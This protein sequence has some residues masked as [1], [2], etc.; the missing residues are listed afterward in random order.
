MSKSKSFAFIQ[1][2]VHA[3]VLCA[4]ACAAAPRALA[5]F[6]AASVLGFVH[7]A[8]GAAVPQSEVTLTNTETHVVRHVTTDEAGRYQFV[9]VPVGEYTVESVAPGFEKAA[10]PSFAL[11]VNAQQRVDLSMPV[12]A[13][14]EQVD[15]TAEPTLLETETSSRG[16]VIGEY[17][18]QNLPLNG[19]SYADLALLVPGVRKSVLENQ[20]T[21]SREASFNV[22]GQRSA[23]NNFLLDGLDNNNYGTSNQGFANEN[24]PPSP[25]AI[26]EFRVETDNYSAEYGRSSGA[27]I[28]ATTRSG[29]DHIAGEIWEY[30]R[31]TALNAIG[32]FNVAGGKPTLIRNQFGG[33][34]GGPILKDRYFYFADYEGTRQIAKAFQTAVLPTDAQKA[35]NLGYALHNPLTAKTYAN[36]VVPTA[37]FSPLARLVFGALPAAPATT[38]AT[39]YTYASFPRG[40]IQD[41][42]GDG[43]VDMQLTSRALLFTR[44]SQHNLIIFDPPAIPGAAGGNANGNVAGNNKQ[45]AVGLTYTVSPRVIADVR[46]GSTWNRGGKS[47]IGVGQQSLLTQAG[48]TDGLPT[49]PQIV[50]PLNGQ[51]ITGYTQFGDQTS[52]PQ[53]QNPWILDPKVNLT[54]LRGKQSLRF[55]YEW[56]RVQTTISDFNPTFGQ[57]N[58]NGQFSRVGSGAAAA[59]AIVANLADFIFGLRSA[60]QLNNF[61]VVTLQ[62]RYHFLYVQDDIKVTP[63][64]TINAGLRYEIVT[65][66][67]TDGNHLANFDPATATLQQATGG[68]IYNRA[69]VN[70][71]YNNLGPR[72]G[73]AYSADSKTVLRGG[74]GISYTQ[75]NREGGENLLAYSGPYI[76]NASIN[77]LITQPLCTS[78]TQDQTACFRPTQQGYASTLVDPVAFSPLKAQSR[79][80]PRNNPTGYIQSYFAG[81]QHQVGKD[82]VLDLAYVGSKGTHLMTLAD[83]NQAAVQPLTAKCNLAAGVTSGCLGL[84]T[85][86]PVPNFNTIEIAYGAGFSNY[87]SL[88]FKVEK[89]YSK[90]L[91]LLNSFTYSRSFDN[92]SG[93][94]ETSGGDNSR[95]NYFNP[96]SDYGPS[97]YDQPLNDTTSMVWDLPLFRTGD[98]V[99]HKLLGGWQATAISTQTSGLVGNLNYSPN[100]N[101]TLT[102]LYTFRPNLVGSA[103]LPEAHRGRVNGAG[104]NIQ[105]LN[106]ATTAAAGG[107][108]LTPTGNNPFGSASRNSFRSPA[109]HTLDFGLHKSFG[110]WNEATRL[111]LRGEAFNVLNE[112]NFY[113]PDTN[114]SDATFG[115]ISAAFPAR[116]LQVA[117]KLYF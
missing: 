9:S 76:V 89:R 116:Q 12:G 87:N 114:R 23:F 99:A 62:Q 42:K 31:N 37:D 95:V 1:P 109:Y 110:L 4:A 104:S 32:P 3:A 29:T 64:L 25:D 30:N 20:T 49:E 102:G 50:R 28:N 46:F 17:E 98:S 13:T 82:V 115:Q 40:T 54:V 84:Q 43:R 106:A 36:G 41:D 61:R 55:G 70:T 35:G 83:Y 73:F 18:V 59:P 100:A 85:R 68:S 6:D 24:I 27:V 56:Q 79:Y 80:I 52:N 53:F 71:Q 92:A 69:L 51:A 81:T 10:T 33:A 86:R 65:P 11:T 39:S 19:R 67:W 45:L 63:K 93:H 58:Y 105:F 44:Y 112:S 88:Q 101:Q 15:V 111:D 108:V 74:Y 21:T 8:S 78:D 47:P 14:T 7:D 91:S 16:Q 26:G 2:G 117:A 94:L 66:Q 60:Y 72:F 48:I 103:I 22:N 77:Q 90:G 75:F 107:T 38:G 96:S 113:F 97:S 34:V 5:Q 57:D